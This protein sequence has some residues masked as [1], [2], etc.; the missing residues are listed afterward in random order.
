MQHRDWFVWSVAVAFV[1]VDGVVVFR[2]IICSTPYALLARHKITVVAE[3]D[4]PCLPPA[5]W[6]NAQ[7]AV[8]VPVGHFRLPAA[9]GREVRRHLADG[10]VTPAV[11]TLL[12][13][14]FIISCSEGKGNTKPWIGGSRFQLP[15]EVVLHESFQRFRTLYK[16]VEKA[17]RQ[18]RNARVAGASARMRVVQILYDCPQLVEGLEAQV[19]AVRTATVLRLCVNFYAAFGRPART[20]GGAGLISTRCSTV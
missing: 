12:G 14:A 7:A 5:I 8:V 1:A 17:V 6:V 2:P 13:E 3:H 11:C 16:R 9:N 4:L 19:S 10:I 15:G 18:A 20:R